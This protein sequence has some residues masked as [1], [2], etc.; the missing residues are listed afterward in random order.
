MSSSDDAGRPRFVAVVGG[1]VL[2]ISSAPIPVGTVLIEDGRIAAVGD[3]VPIPDGARIID[4]SG[5]WVLPGLFDSHAHVG[6]HEDVNGTEGDDLNNTSSPDTSGLRAVDGIDIE[7]SAFRDAL[8]GGI[9]SV[10]VLPGSSNPLGGET[11]AMKTWGGRTV[12]EQVIRSPLGLKSGFGENPKVTYAAKGLLP[13][14]RP[15]TAYVIRQALEDARVYAARRDEASRSDSPFG[16]DLRLD[17]L[18]R[19]LRRETSWAVHV[20]RHDDIA[21]A[22]RIAEE[23]GLDLVINHGTGAQRIVDV[24]AERDLPVL[25]GPLVTARAKLE[26]ADHSGATPGVLHRAGVRFALTTDHPEVPI[27]MLTL[28]AALAVKEGLDR[29]AAHRAVTLAPAEILHLDARIGSLRPGRDADI[30]IWS[31][32]PVDSDTRAEH[33]LI[34]GRTVYTWDAETG[35]GTVAARTDRFPAGTLRP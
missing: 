1:R 4:A 13:M 31:G 25:V 9:T 30:V 11:V 32:D 26:L 14:T 21:T 5:K 18:A 34:D 23:Y 2:P 3:S 6:I 27:Y 29:S 35:A 16:R 10:V 28:Q 20:H 15:G 24:I 17:A 8:S 33:V 22:I 19:L 12:D 7:D